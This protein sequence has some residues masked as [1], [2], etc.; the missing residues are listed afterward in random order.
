MCI[1]KGTYLPSITVSWPHQVQI[2]SECGLKKSINFMHIGRDAIFAA[3]SVV[4]K[5]VP[6]MEIWGGVPAVKIG[7]RK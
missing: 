7:E 3:G 6:P 1:G 2:G 5:S 4:N